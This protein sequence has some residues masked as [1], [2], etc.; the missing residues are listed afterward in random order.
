MIDRGTTTR[1]EDLSRA[2]RSRATEADSINEFIAERLREV[3]DLLHQQQ[4]NPFRVRA[5]RQAAD[6]IVSVG[7]NLRELFEREGTNGL[8]ALPGVGPKI[9]AAIAEMLRT[10]RWNQL[11]RLRGTLDPEQIFRA[12]PG[13]GAGL[14]RRIHDT[15]HVDTLEALEVA[16]HDGRLEAVPDIGPRRAAII[17]AALGNMLGRPRLRAHPAEEPSV[18]MLLAVD[19]QYRTAAAP[20][21]TCQRLRRDG[22][23]PPAR[24]GSPSFTRSEDSGTSPC[25]SRTRRGPTSWGVLTTGS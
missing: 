8:E 1:Y 19:E 25:C 24:R 4:A 10:G 7:E 16:A 20:R 15:L 2:R 3:S 6:T 23:I 22:S 13:V 17:R 11:E 18:D 14:A 9:A 12:I 21:G 5:Y